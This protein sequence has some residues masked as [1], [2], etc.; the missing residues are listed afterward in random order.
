MLL[1]S[2]S[3]ITDRHPVVTTEFLLPP[4]GL[5]VP[6]QKPKVIGTWPSVITN[7]IPRLKSALG[8]CANQT[9]E[10]LDWIEMQK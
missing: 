4:A 6:C 3:L 7:D 5:I 2:C 10:Y 9:Q 1:S 8:K